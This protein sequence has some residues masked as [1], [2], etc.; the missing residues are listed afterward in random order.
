MSRRTTLRQ[1]WVET[2]GTN[3]DDCAVERPHF[4]E[5]DMDA[6]HCARACASLI[7]EAGLP[8]DF[9]VE[10]KALMEE[11]ATIYYG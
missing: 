4:L 8:S 11:M 3:P 2:F 9:V 1:L 10:P 7:I 6:H 5:D